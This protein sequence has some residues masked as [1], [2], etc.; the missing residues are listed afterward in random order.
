MVSLINVPVPDSNIL[1]LVKEVEPL[2]FA[3]LPEVPEPVIVP[4]LLGELLVIVK[5]G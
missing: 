5:F 4:P 3:S 1:E 2:N